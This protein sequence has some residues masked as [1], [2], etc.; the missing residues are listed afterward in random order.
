MGS[1]SRLQA[2]FVKACDLAKCTIEFGINLKG[3]L[4]IFFVI[5]ILSIV[6]RV[7]SS[8]P[9]WLHYEENYYLNI[10]QNYADRGELTPYMWQ[11]GDSNIIA[12]SGSGYGIIILI[13][14]LNLVGESLIWGRML[15]LRPLSEM[16]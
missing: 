12:G 5:I 14:W 8:A 11:L 2:E 15:M 10:A 9:T 3:T 13:Y 16:S 7:W 4:D 1:S 6:F